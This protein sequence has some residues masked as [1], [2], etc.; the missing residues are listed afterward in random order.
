MR[1]QVCGGMR[2]SILYANNGM[3]T[4][5]AQQKKVLNLSIYF[6]LITLNQRTYVDNRFNLRAIILNPET[7][8]TVLYQCCYRYTQK[9]ITSLW[10]HI[11][12]T[13]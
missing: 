4:S 13:R 1:G 7:V 12:A 8:S 2:G 5:W 3:K 9:E 11:S 6:F 10:W